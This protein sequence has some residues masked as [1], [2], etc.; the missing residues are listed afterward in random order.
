MSRHDHDHDHG[1]AD[2]GL[3]SAVLGRA[4]E[5]CAES[6][7]LVSRRAALGITAGL[8]SSAFVPRWAEAATGDPRLLVVVL[9]GGMDGINTVIPHGDG[10][11][12]EMR[13]NIAI[14]RAQSI[15][16][17]D[18]FSLNKALTGFGDLFKAGDAA[19][20]HAAGL[21]LRNRSHFDCQD[22][23]E[24]GLP[25]LGSNSTG[26][27]NRL[28]TAMPQ[29]SPIVS[30][31]AIQIGEAPLLLRG[32]APVL[33]WSP[34][35]FQHPDAT[36][37]DRVVQMLRNTDGELAGALERGL[38]AD[39]LAEQVDDGSGWVSTFRQSFR[40]AGRLLAAADGPR[41]AVLSVN[42]FDTHSDQGVTSGYLFD[43]LAELDI[44][45]KDFKE[46]VGDVW[47]DTV[48]VMATE[49]G[50]TVHVNG[51]KGTDHG[52]GTVA[53]LAGGSVAGGKVL[54]TWPGIAKKD[55]YEES[56]LTPTTDLRAIFKGVL[57]DHIGVPK[58]VLDETVFPGSADVPAMTGLV[59]PSATSGARLAA[60]AGTYRAAG[61]RPAAAIARYRQR[62]GA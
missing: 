42:N 21:P 19:V 35:W 29:G 40:G 14:S 25:G 10:S 58:D 54:G 7:L 8:F 50:R 4:T 1:P 47:K 36:L 11:Y 31:G 59:K 61:L 22:N 46:A 62:Y 49:F 48:I 51:T 32:P 27:M 33:G 30:R 20:V 6:R 55:L 17:D 2:L 18:F 38:K 53:M 5:G 13:G 57:M 3:P 12:N 34:T 16:L 15:G 41:M 60:A 26:W 45:L 23:L 56:D 43:A 24:N 28:L 9:R 52:V 44:A 39:A 37:T